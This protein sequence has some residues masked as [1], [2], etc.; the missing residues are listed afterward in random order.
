LLPQFKIVD[1]SPLVLEQRKAK[2]EGEIA[3]IRQAC[4]IVDAGHRRV[5]EVL[6]E[7]MTELDLAAA[8]ED[9]NRRAGH[10]GLSFFRRPD[11][12]MSRGPV[13][14]G[15]NLMAASGIVYSI[16]GVGMS[17]ALPVGPSL[18]KIEKGEPIVIDVPTLYQG[19][20][21]D[22]SRTYVVG[23]ASDGLRSL[24]SGLKDISDCI[25]ANITPG[26]TCREVFHLAWE[27][28][29]KLKVDDCFMSFG[30]RQ[31]TSFIGHGVG[32]ECN[33]PPMLSANDDSRLEAGYVLALDI[34]MLRLGV[35]VV[36]LED[37]VLVTDGR[38]EILTISPR[39]L[40]EVGG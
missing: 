29:R 4:H 34:H 15:A 22:Q 31:N 26:R 2:D 33:E 39:E 30:E 7:G 40:F 11:F 10:E 21:A 24:H 14:S 23:K 35:G 27:R 1:I 38:A 6:R 5:L 25:I 18:K 8:V 36:K 32:L 28:A 16:A 3:C 20:H 19:Y 37:T 13:G 12:F 9:A 17:A